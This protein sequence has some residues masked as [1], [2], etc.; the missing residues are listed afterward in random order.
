MWPLLSVCAGPVA[1]TPAIP[2]PCASVVLLWS[3]C[4]SLPVRLAGRPLP[5]SSALTGDQSSGRLAERRELTAL[6]LRVGLCRSRPVLTRPRV[7]AALALSGRDCFS[8]PAISHYSSGSALFGLFFSDFPGQAVSPHPGSA[9]LLSLCLATRGCVLGPVGNRSHWCG[10][11]Q[12]CSGRGAEGRSV[13]AQQGRVDRGSPSSAD[14]S[15][16]DLRTHL[17][18][19]D[20]ALDLVWF[21]ETQAH[22]DHVNSLGRLV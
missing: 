16:T 19:S 6:G 5:V 14:L 10:W 7:P 21:L 15:S 3:A 9:F 12:R 11:L 13:H 22:F 1:A 20:L 2:G 18:A 4:A 8:A 17:L